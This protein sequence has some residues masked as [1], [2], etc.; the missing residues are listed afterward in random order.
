MKLETGNSKLEPEAAMKEVYE[1]EVYQIAEDLSDSIRY[2]YDNW[3]EK[4]RRTIGYQIIR[5][6][7]SIA[8][9]IAEGMVVTCL[10]TGKY[11]T[12]IPED[13]SKKQKH[14]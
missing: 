4:V 6:S 7:D 11:F 13:H 10:L 9:N 3:S 12:D 14:G 2:A 1:L 5:S 8:T